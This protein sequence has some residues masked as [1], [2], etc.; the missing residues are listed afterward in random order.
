[1]SGNHRRLVPVFALLS[2]VV[3]MMITSS[4]FASAVM[5][6]V[7]DPSELTFTDLD[8]LIQYTKGR[9]V[10][11]KVVSDRDV[12]NFWEIIRSHG[13]PNAG[14]TGATVKAAMA[15]PATDPANEGVLVLR[16]TFDKAAVLDLISRHYAEHVNEH[17]ADE[18]QKELGIGQ[19]GQLVCGFPT[20]CF[21][22]PLRDRE[23]HIIDLGDTVVFSSHKKGD[24]VFTQNV[25]DVLTG[26]IPMKAEADR[27]SKVTYA[28]EPTPEE[29]SRILAQIGDSYARYRGG[30][31][32]NRR[33]VRRFSATIRNIVVDKKVAGVKNDVGHMVKV[34]FHVERALG[35]SVDSKILSLTL[36]FDSADIAQ[37]VKASA[38]KHLVA[39]MKKPALK[40]SVTALQNPKITVEGNNVVLRVALETEAD[41]MHAFSIMAG[42]VARGIMSTRQTP[43]VRRLRFVADQQARIGRRFEQNVN[44]EL[45]ATSFFSIP[46]KLSLMFTSMKARTDIRRCEDAYV[47]LTSAKPEKI[48]DCVTKIVDAASRNIDD[49]N[50]MITSKEKAVSQAAAK[51]SLVPAL[52]MQLAKLRA[53]KLEMSTNARVLLMTVRSPAFT[54]AAGKTDSKLDKKLVEYAQ[55]SGAIMPVKPADKGAPVVDPLAVLDTPAANASGSIN[56]PTDL[57]PAVAIPAG[58][59]LIQASNEYQAALKA[60][61]DAAATDDQVKLRQ[62]YDQYLVKFQIYQAMVERQ[63][64][65]K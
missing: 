40:S 6:V 50:R 49:L 33:G 30:N 43:V 35:I 25:V 19:A 20:H 52:R 62:A 9:L 48:Q 16:G 56:A 57:T 22:M 3:T 31:M 51:G 18:R 27:S 12:A 21:V 36:Q 39:E 55:K 5:F 8:S 23:L 41:Q 34:T 11:D 15:V 13:A 64:S 32:D 47:D 37:A 28:F 4:V 38:V 17:I 60:Y 44:E 42:Y 61:T 7:N 24:L 58:M 53:E 1:M 63:D 46:T 59:T 14:G 10:N 45:A 29:R 2:V 26:K 65:S 54:S